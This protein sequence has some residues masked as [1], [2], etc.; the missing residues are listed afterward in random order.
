F[1]Q[2][3]NQAFTDLLAGQ[4]DI[5]FDSPAP[6]AHLIR[7]GKIRALVSLGA[8]RIAELSDVPTMAESGLPDLRVV[9]WNGLVAPVRTPDA[10]VAKLNAAVNGALMSAT[11]RET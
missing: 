11:I 7:E 8:K 3:M 2:P 4:M 5:I 10:I 1:Y 6:L 9:T